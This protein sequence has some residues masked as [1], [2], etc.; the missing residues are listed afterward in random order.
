VRHLLFW[1]LFGVS[2]SEDAAMSESKLESIRVREGCCDH[3]K[4]K[5]YKNMFWWGVGEGMPMLRH[6]FPLRDQT[7]PSKV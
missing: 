4:R 6:P 5:N 3:K 2:L 1:L 7:H